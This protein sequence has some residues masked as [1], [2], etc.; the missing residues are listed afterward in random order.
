MEE[1]NL[2]CKTSEEFLQAVGDMM[3]EYAE[4]KEIDIWS[5]SKAISKKLNKEEGKE[6]DIRDAAQFTPNRR[7]S[8]LDEEVLNL[9]QE[10]NKIVDEPSL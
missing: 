9:E 10:F 4:S 1:F 5:L 3:I 6:Q 7:E 2:K 8:L